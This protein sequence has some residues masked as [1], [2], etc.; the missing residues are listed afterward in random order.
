MCDFLGWWDLRAKWCYFVTLFLG[1]V[2]VRGCLLGEGLMGVVGGY[3][4][5]SFT[6]GIMGWLYRGIKFLL[7]N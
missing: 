1:W 7:I 2:W 4:Y 3:N 6:G 5:F